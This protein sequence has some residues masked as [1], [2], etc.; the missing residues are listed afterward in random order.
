MTGE[1]DWCARAA[2]LRKVE[3][4]LLSGEVI[5]ETRFGMDMVRWAETAKLS[6]VK[7]ALDEAIR[8]CAISRGETPGRR[9]YAMR[10][11]ARPY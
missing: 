5:T 4:A 6:E 8:N 10:A 3:E 1:T 9:R 2:K 7:A 11:R